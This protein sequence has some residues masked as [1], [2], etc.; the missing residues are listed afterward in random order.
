MYR[1]LKLVDEVLNW[2]TPYWIALNQTMQS[3]I[4]SSFSNDCTHTHTHTHKHMTMM[5]N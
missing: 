5:I 2:T 3:Q 1:H 4:L